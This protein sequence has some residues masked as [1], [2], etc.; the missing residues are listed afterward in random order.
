MLSESR[1]GTALPIDT[2]RFRARE[3]LAPLVPWL[4][5][6][7][8]D[9][10]AALGSMLDQKIGFEIYVQAAHIKPATATT[11]PSASWRE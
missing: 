10:L 5:P 7:D 4:P 6:L 2:A 9:S 11:S 8:D 3:Y 1:S